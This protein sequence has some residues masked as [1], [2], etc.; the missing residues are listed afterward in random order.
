MKTKKKRQKYSKRYEEKIKDTKRWRDNE[1]E[2]K[3][4]RK[5]GIFIFFVHL[6][7]PFVVSSKLINFE[8]KLILIIC[9]KVLE[10]ICQISLYFY[11]LHLV[12]CP[13]FGILVQV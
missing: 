11:I 9:P 5:I 12:G 2:R 10:I 7:R 6:F 4:W 13:W 1:R 8:K 3:G